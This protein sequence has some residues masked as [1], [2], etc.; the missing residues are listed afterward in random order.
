MND[1]GALT[2]MKPN[3]SSRLKRLGI[4]AVG[5]L[6]AFLLGLI[7]MWMTARERG[8]QRDMAQRALQLSQ[9]QNAIAF[10]TISARHGDYEPARQKASDF[11]SS[12]HTEIDKGNQSFFTQS[13]REK[14]SLLIAP[15][16]EFITLLARSDPTSADRLAELYLQYCKAV[17]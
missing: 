12:V 16:D 15:R 10:A 3:G 1:A 7:P 9:L 11:F 8:Q 4:Y 13:Q 2:G 14:I 6:V 5:L 17:E